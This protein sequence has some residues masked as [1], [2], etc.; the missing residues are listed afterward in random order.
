MFDTDLDRLEVEYQALLEH[1]RR[2]NLQNADLHLSRSGETLLLDGEVDDISYKRIAVNLLQQL[3]GERYRIEDRLRIQGSDIGDAAL[4]VKVGRILAEEP[5]FREFDLVVS[6]KGEKE[7]LRKRDVPGGDHIHADIQNG[8]VTLSGKVNS[9]THRRLA[10]ALLW[11]I[12][13]CHRVDNL[14]VV[15]PPEEDTDAQITDA[16]RMALEKDPLIDADQI[17]VA[18]RAGIVELE[19]QLSSK[20]LRTLAVRDV[21]SVPGIWEVYNRIDVG[22]G[23]G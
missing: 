5:V 3:V 10:E 11:W 2:I 13:G 21:W 4:A 16:V 6:R 14:L 1:D 20:E 19:G 15:A 17:N 12:D 8:V 7:I 22:H 9:L 23:L 18:T